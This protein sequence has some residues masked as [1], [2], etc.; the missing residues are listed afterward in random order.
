MDALYK[1]N[2]AVVNQKSFR[3]EIIPGPVFSPTKSVSLLDNV[4]VKQAMNA[5]QRVVQRIGDALDDP[6]EQGKKRKQLEFAKQANKS[7]GWIS[8]ILAERRGVR[9][10]DLDAIAEVLGVPPGELVREF[11]DALVE[12]TPLERRFLDRIRQLRPE[13]RRAYMTTLTVM[14]EAS[15]TAQSRDLPSSSGGRIRRDH[16]ETPPPALPIEQLRRACETVLNV[17]AD[18]NA[19]TY[20]L[21]HR[22][23]PSTGSDEAPGGGVAD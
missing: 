8:N 22:S 14:A 12:T 3:M 20:P 17:L 18:F 9:L 19:T 23:L 4:S 6:T 13:D 21:P 11:D 2:C 1:T 16:A 5:L 10:K 7:A 15:K